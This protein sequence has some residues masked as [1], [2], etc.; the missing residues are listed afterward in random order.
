MWFVYVPLNWIERCGGDFRFAPKPFFLLSAHILVINPLWPKQSRYSSTVCLF[1]LETV[2]F[3]HVWWYLCLYLCI[4]AL[5][6]LINVSPYCIS[7][8]NIWGDLDIEEYRIDAQ[9]FLKWQAGHYSSIFC[10][11]ELC[12]WWLRS[13]YAFPKMS[14]WR[15][16]ELKRWS[17]RWPW[18]WPFRDRSLKV[19]RIVQ[20]ML[21]FIEIYEEHL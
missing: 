11:F 6:H 8:G 5:F 21:V 9:I 4:L 10:N 14:K 17:F 7:I 12:N 3:F 2:S 18:P 16:I 19:F 20:Y 1:C 15:N 13:L